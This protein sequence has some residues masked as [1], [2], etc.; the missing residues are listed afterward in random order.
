MGNG[1]IKTHLGP[2]VQLHHCQ[3]EAI[4]NDRPHRTQQQTTVLQQKATP[5]DSTITTNSPH[6]EVLTVPHFAK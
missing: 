5:T 4:S 1:I 2:R 3:P 6:P